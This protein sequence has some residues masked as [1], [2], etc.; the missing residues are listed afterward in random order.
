MKM[1]ILHKY[2]K[3][4]YFSLFLMVLSSTTFVC[5]LHG[6][7][8]LTTEPRTERLQSPTPHDDELR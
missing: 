3:Q 5:R 8:L 1:K 6:K 4:K 2:I 7:L